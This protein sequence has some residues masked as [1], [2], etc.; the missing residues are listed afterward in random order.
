M[1]SLDLSVIQY[2]SAFEERGDANLPFK[3]KD[4]LF[5]LREL[6]LSE[7]SFDE[8]I[9]TPSPSWW[10]RTQAFL[11][12]WIQRKGPTPP[13]PSS[14]FGLQSMANLRKWKA[15][16]DWT[17]L[18]HLELDGY[19]HMFF[20]EMQGKLP[21]LRSLSLSD[22]WYW[23][24]FSN[25]L[26]SL[27]PLSE[28]SVRDYKGS[29]DWSQVFEHHGSTITKIEIRTACGCGFLAP[30]REPVLSLDELGAIRTWCHSLST[31][32]ID[33][34]LNITE[35]STALTLLASNKKLTSLELTFEE[36]RSI[37][38]DILHVELSNMSLPT[39]FDVNTDGMLGPFD[40]TMALHMFHQL[41][42]I[43]EGSELLELRMNRRYYGSD[44]FSFGRLWHLSR[45]QV[46][47][48]SV[49]RRDGSRKEEGEVRCDSFL[50]D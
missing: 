37:P 29:V 23:G 26:L 20:D 45:V 8:F 40:S 41:R 38:D 39:P 12:P 24:N 30:G 50:E 31:L 16:M 19:N 4:T 34:T 33:A 46:W 14:E 32:I 18:E 35:L 3:S 36:V 17:K 43:K 15:A 5:P 6:H 25:F 27:N 2:E 13:L 9:E 42:S 47:S 49:L 10:D 7:Y 21:G 28:L 1:Q 11:A 22:G 48:C 44:T